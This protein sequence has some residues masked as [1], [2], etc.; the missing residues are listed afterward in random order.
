MDKKELEIIKELMAELEDKMQFDENDLSARLGR[1][2]PEVEVPELEGEMPEEE[3]SEE[4]MEEEL[5]LLEE[6]MTP[7]EKLKRRLLKLRS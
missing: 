2:K 7:E 4:L 1:K 6:E 5:P 3:E